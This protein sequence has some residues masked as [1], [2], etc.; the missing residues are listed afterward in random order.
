MGRSR[1]TKHS[2]KPSME[3][4]QAVP[5]RNQ[6]GQSSSS[7]PG[8]LPDQITTTVHHRHRARGRRRSPPF[9]GDP[10]Y[11]DLSKGWLPTSKPQ[12]APPTPE[13]VTPLNLAH[14]PFGPAPLGFWP[15]GSAPELPGAA[16]PRRDHTGGDGA[17]H[18]ARRGR[19]P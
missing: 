1:P 15:D 19:L 12:R 10:A 2:S 7:L 6:Y 11:A 13:S 5:K 16:P 14:P 4:A 18:T 9:S 17:V 3:T 8:A